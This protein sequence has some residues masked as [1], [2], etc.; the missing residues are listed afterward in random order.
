MVLLCFYMFMVH[1]GL[2]LPEPKPL[3]L[4]S[5]Q[6]RYR[7]GS[8]KQFWWHS[9]LILFISNSTPDNWT[10]PQYPEIDKLYE[11]T[12]VYALSCLAQQQRVLCARRAGHMKLLL[13]V[14]RADSEPVPTRAAVWARQSN[15]QM[16]LQMGSL[17]NRWQHMLTQASGD[18]GRDI[19]Q[20]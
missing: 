3:F 16:W 15:L 6:Y 2:E 7:G 11:K 20:Q 9:C 1:I 12:A 18:P 19:S 4:V 17:A 5:M 10:Y 8:Y 13:M 14:I